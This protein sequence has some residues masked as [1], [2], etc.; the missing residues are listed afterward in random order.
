MQLGEIARTQQVGTG[1][2][3]A[4]RT[5]SEPK[6]VPTPAQ[7][8]AMVE[9]RLARLRQRT[10]EQVDEEVVEFIAALKAQE[11]EIL[12]AIEQENELK[13]TFR[14][15]T[16]DRQDAERRGA[17]YDALKK[18][19][20]GQLRQYA[21]DPQYA[22]AYQEASQ[23][24]NTRRQA[25]NSADQIADDH[26]RAYEGTDERPQPY[27][28]GTADV[29]NSNVESALASNFVVKTEKGETATFTWKGVGYRSVRPADPIV[30]AP[31]LEIA[32]FISES[33]KFRNERNDEVENRVKS[34]GFLIAFRREPDGKGGKL[35]S[36]LDLIQEEQGVF[37]KTLTAFCAGKGE[38]TLVRLPD[39]Q[40]EVLL[41]RV[42]PGASE[43]FPT[44]ATNAQVAN[45]LFYWDDRNNPGARTKRKMYSI[46]LN[47]RNDDEDENVPT[48]NNVRPGWFGDAMAE[49]IRREAQSQEN[50]KRA[51]GL[52]DNSQVKDLIT[53]QGLAYLG[54]VGTCVVDARPTFTIG[55]REHQH[56]LTLHI[57]GL[58]ND[59]FQ[60]TAFVEG[61]VERLDPNGTWLA[62]AIKAP[63]SRRLLREK[64]EW[65]EVVKANAWSDAKWQVNREA[66]QRGAVAV[67]RENQ[68]DL[69]GLENGK[70]GGLY[71]VRGN[72]RG[73]FL[74]NDSVGRPQYEQHAVGFIV[75]R[76]GSDLEI[77][78]NI[79]YGKSAEIAKGNRGK[80]PLTNLTNNLR[81][82]L[83][84]VFWLLNR[85]KDNPKVNTPA[86]LVPVK[87]VR[88]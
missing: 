51:D 37:V 16:T 82:V 35:P 34:D 36:E 63:Q 78:W 68:T 25:Q 48:F 13:E 56:E 79:P 65:K 62:P 6:P 80:L 29:I 47:E 28:K 86:H 40:G 1:Q 5:A 17:E 45:Q 49:Q 4:K 11:E 15:G 19:I 38:K 83:G 60:V 39:R 53:A 26:R 14:Q 59:E 20:Q 43:A 9:S 27:G 3:A 8:K 57:A 87:Q 22:P 58:E 66:A 72:A 52:R 71:A 81:G 50:W 41:E 30:S 10:T 61:T 2:N 31:A 64:A 21:G 18:E 24:M 76:S 12:D 77:V 69:F 75:Q 46:D 67:T 44:G 33:Q 7:F 73:K 70:D 23:L 32:N 55:G 74:G 88:E 85:T 84:N 54:E 42:A